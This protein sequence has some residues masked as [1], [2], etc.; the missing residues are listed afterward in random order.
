[1]YKMLHSVLLILAIAVNFAKP[2][3]T[4]GVPQNGSS[5]LEQDTSL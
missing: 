5:E 4:V 2:Q 3:T 1:M